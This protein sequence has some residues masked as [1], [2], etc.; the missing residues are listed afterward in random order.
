M[1]ISIIAVMT[2]FTFGQSIWARDLFK[3]LSNTPSNYIEKSKCEKI[4]SK[5]A[6]HYTDEYFQAIFNPPQN[7][8]STDKI[9]SELRSPDGDE[10]PFHIQLNVLKL[11]LCQKRIDDVVYNLIETK[12]Y[13]DEAERTK[14][15]QNEYTYPTSSVQAE[16]AY[17]SANVYVLKKDEVRKASKRNKTS[18]TQNPFPISKFSVSVFDN[19]GI[20][21]LER[22]YTLYS[23]AQ[24]EKMAQAMS[25]TLNVMDAVKVETKITFREDLERENYVVEHTPSDIYRLALRIFTME[26]K[27]LI[28]EYNSQGL[29]FSNMDMLAAAYEMG[30]IS[31]SEIAILTSDESFYKKDKSFLKK[32]GSYVMKIGMTAAQINPATAPYAI[33][34]I[35]LY[36]SY[37]EAK[38]GKDIIEYEN[39]YFN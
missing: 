10:L 35:I 1:K 38:K 21:V 19:T 27:K 25:L 7:I 37:Q 2:L 3:D 20:T 11:A 18:S 39:F 32:M 36:N 30:V 16:P 15:S 4:N 29:P 34:G 17:L 24:I 12:I 6:R 22:L 33:V 31:E 8:P 23:P 28:R 26:K 13:Q 9:V 5:Y 14:N